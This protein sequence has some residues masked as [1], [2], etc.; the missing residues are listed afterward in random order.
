MSPG[1]AAACCSAA[2][3][4][5][6][7]ENA[8]SCP[9]ADPLLSGVWWIDRRNDLIAIRAERAFRVAQIYA[10]H[11]GQ[12]GD[13]HH[14]RGAVDVDVRNQ[15]PNGA[16]KPRPRN[17]RRHD[18]IAS[19]HGQ[20]AWSTTT[21]RYARRARVIGFAKT[22]NWFTLHPHGALA[23]SQ[24]TNHASRCTRRKICPTSRRCTSSLSACSAIWDALISRRF[25]R[26]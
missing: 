18:S 3:S 19:C 13:Q 8:R 9:R 17:Q 14:V 7:S 15:A 24:Q 1:S 16:W 5:S 6:R 21:S 25:A 20:S 2:S 23:P 26:A 4:R 11:R 22:S 12:L 10:G